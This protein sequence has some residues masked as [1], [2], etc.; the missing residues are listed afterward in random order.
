MR[1]IFDSRVGKSLER[2][3]LQ[4][5][6]DAS[7][8][9]GKAGRAE[10]SSGATSLQSL[11]GRVLLTLTGTWALDVILPANRKPWQQTDER[12]GLAD[13]CFVPEPRAR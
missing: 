13:S 3:G 10:I 1:W 6:L 4:M 8:T 9:G 5:T 2:Q 7:S 11:Y 12:Q